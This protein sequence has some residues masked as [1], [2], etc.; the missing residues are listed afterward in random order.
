MVTEKPMKSP[1]QK[2]KHGWMRRLVRWFKV[3]RSV[4]PE[5]NSDAPA[6]DN[7]RVCGGYHS[8]SRGLPS[9]ELR[10]A[11]MNR[12]EA[13]RCTHGTPMTPDI[14]CRECDDWMHRHCEGAKN[15]PNPRRA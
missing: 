11:W 12:Y 3:R 1:M 14:R 8:G 15:R 6:M 5:C 13:G 2:I 9:A 7:C 10:E 4:C